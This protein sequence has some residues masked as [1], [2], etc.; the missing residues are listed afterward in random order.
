[1]TFINISTLFKWGTELEIDTPQ[2]K[3]PFWMR[4][5]GDA[6]INRARVYALRNISKMNYITLGDVV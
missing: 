5:V 2:G 4:I 6:D 3:Q 1:M